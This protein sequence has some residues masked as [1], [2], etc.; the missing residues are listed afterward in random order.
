[1]IIALILMPATASAGWFSWW[2]GRGQTQVASNAVAVPAM[3]FYGLAIAGGVL[4]A[5]MRRRK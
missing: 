4:V 1:L 3:D 2:F 5:M